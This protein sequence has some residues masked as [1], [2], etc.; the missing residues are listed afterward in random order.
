MPGLPFFEDTSPG[1]VRT[2]AVDINISSSAGDSTGFGGLADTASNLL[3]GAT[4]A[5]WADHLLSL[6]LHQGFAPAV[7]YLDLMIAA[8]EGA[9]EAEIGDQ[10]TL[11][12]GVTDAFDELFTGKIIAIERRGDSIRRYRL[13]NGSHSLAQSR[14]NQSVNNM[15]V[16]DAINFASSQFNYPPQADIGGNDDA[17]L[18][19]VFNDAASVW[20][21][22]AYLAGLR[23]ANLWFDSSDQLQLADQLE[24]GDRVATYTWGQDLL[25][26]NLWQRTPHSGVTTAYGNDYMND[27]FILRKQSNPNKAEQGEGA[28]HRFYRDGLLQSQQD[29]TM[30]AASASVNGHRQTSLS[31]VV[32]S[33]TAAVGPGRVIE[34]SSLPGGGDGNYLI[35]HVQHTFDHLNGWQSRLSVSQVDGADSQGGLSGAIGG[36]L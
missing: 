4:A 16:E 5:S 27:Q 25:E 8:T 33:G 28:P 34:L 10:G 20:E 11:A 36:L 26:A 6:S 24:Q 29:L 32:V 22:I 19:V 12:I 2:P 17:L 21:H 13:G 14:I 31:E 15:S 18:Q 9:P 35:H 1:P 23:G 3:G 7:D 30:R